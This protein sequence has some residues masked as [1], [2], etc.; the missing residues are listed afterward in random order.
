MPLRDAATLEH[1][2][3]DVQACNDTNRVDVFVFASDTQALLMARWTTWA[4]AP[5]APRCR[6]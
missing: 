4:R 6:R 3:F 2:F 1:G 5:A